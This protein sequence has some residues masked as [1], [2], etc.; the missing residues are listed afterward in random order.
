M[1]MTCVDLNVCKK[2]AFNFG[3]HFNLDYFKDYYFNSITK[4]GWRAEIKIAFILGIV[5]KVIPGIYVEMSKEL[6]NID[7][8]D[9]RIIFERRKVSK[10]QFKMK[11]YSLE[12][13]NKYLAMNPEVSV[14]FR[15]Y[16]DDV[17][18]ILGDILWNIAETPEQLDLWIY[19]VLEESGKVGISL[20]SV[21]KDYQ[22]IPR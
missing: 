9:F 3:R 8:E 21:W 4:E 10:I 20:N 7:K 2:I 5:S 22:Y 13:E 17:E 19:T 6:D 18:D 11:P 16:C 1:I 14:I 15:E 12:E